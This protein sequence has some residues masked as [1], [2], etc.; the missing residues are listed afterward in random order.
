MQM[1]VWDARCRSEDF[2]FDFETT[3]LNPRTCKALGVSLATETEKG[4]LPLLP[5]RGGDGISVNQN[6]S[7]KL[8]RSILGS[9]AVKIA[10]NM[11]YD[12]AVALNMGIDVVWPFGCTQVAAFSHDCTRLTYNLRDI[13]ARYGITPAPDFSDFA[14]KIPMEDFST[15]ELAF[16]SIPHAVNTFRLHKI[17]ERCLKMSDQWG[18][19]WDIEMPCVPSIVWIE[20]SGV[21]VDI[22]RA[23]ELRD[24]MLLM[25]E[26]LENEIYELAGGE[27][28]IRS[29]DQLGSI[30]FKKLR[31]PV[32]K[33]S[34][35][36][37]K[38][39]TDKETLEKLNHPI[40]NLLLEYKEVGK[41]RSTFVEAIPKWEVD[42]RIHTNLNLTVARSG[43]LSS[44]QP[45]LQNI[46]H[47]DR[48]GVRKLFIADDGYS[49]AV[50][51]SSQ[52][53]MRIAA[54][55]SG[56]AALYE[57]Y[58]QSGDIHSKTCEAIFGEVTPELRAVAKTINFAVGYGMQEFSLAKRLGISTKKA[59]DYLSRY[60]GTYKGLN[61]YNKYLINMARET[62]YA[63]T[64]GGRRRPLYGINSSDNG[65]RL[66]DERIATNHPIQGT[67]AE[68]Q[69]IA[70]RLLWERFRDTEV[71]CVL[72]VHDELVLE[73]PTDIV[74]EVLVEQV[75]IMST[76]GGRVKFDIPLLAEGKTGQNWGECH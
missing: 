47:Y 28:N 7:K 27:F 3:G 41:L 60:W 24:E 13:S 66:A 36:T 43:R 73:A 17:L 49:L 58:S 15:I 45:N 18:L 25:E 63:Q 57:V 75:E 54:I 5:C 12:M 59:S 52:I 26:E 8:L 51:D 19:Y 67:A 61:K 29:N 50:A 40:V 6:A 70:Q 11:K 69:K 74:D 56:D 44:S 30:L 65:K 33:Y 48:F 46:P 34:A 64:L 72:T 2:A 4:Y 53:E 23:E 31:L 14:G 38:P 10:H 37:H 71:R 9:E 42:G 76:L 35:K 39:S 16:Y 62:G 55:L 21:C 32:A 22:E 1:T 68:I 20:D